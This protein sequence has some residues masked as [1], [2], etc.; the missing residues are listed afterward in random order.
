MKPYK[1]PTLRSRMYVHRVA[2]DECNI[3]YVPVDKTSWGRTFKIS[4]VY[5]CYRNE[6]GNTHPLNVVQKTWKCVK[7]DNDKTFDFA[8]YKSMVFRAMFCHASSTFYRMF[9]Q[10][11]L[12]LE[13]LPC[14]TNMASG[15]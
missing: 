2:H 4:S 8:P 7:L 12:K 3:E 6:P 13:V 5:K 15:M 10:G 1:C 14:S 9:H 11:T